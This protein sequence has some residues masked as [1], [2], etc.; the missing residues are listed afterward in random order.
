MESVG[1]F[2]R[3]LTMGPELGQRFPLAPDEAGVRPL[4]LMEHGIALM[5]ELAVRLGF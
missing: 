2:G 1:P 5:A 4:V 3:D